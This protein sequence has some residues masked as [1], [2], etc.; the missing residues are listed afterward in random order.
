MIWTVFLIIFVINKQINL[1]K[2]SLYVNKNLL[3]ANSIINQLLTKLVMSVILCVLGICCILLYIFSYEIVSFLKYA[4]LFFLSAGVITTIWETD[5]LFYAGT[6]AA[7]IWTKSGDVF[8]IMFIVCVYSILLEQTKIKYVDIYKTL[9]FIIG[10]I[11]SIS[12]VMVKPL[13]AL[14]V[15]KTFFFIILILT[16]YICISILRYRDKPSQWLIIPFSLFS[17][18]V[19]Y[20]ISWY[21]LDV[22]SSVHKF[23]TKSFLLL[24]CIYVTLQ[25]FCFFQNYRLGLLFG[26]VSNRR[27]Q[28]LTRH[29]TEITELIIKY[30]Y[31]PINK[32]DYLNNMIMNKSIGSLNS[33][34]EDIL[35]DL[36]H[37]VYNLKNHINDISSYRMLTGNQIKPERVKISMKTILE[38]A[39]SE[40]ANE[41]N[42]L[43]NNI[44]IEID[45]NIYIIGDPYL[46]MQANETLLF[47][48]NDF[49]AGNTIDI[50]SRHNNDFIYVRMR[51]NTDTNKI[52]LI[53]K[54]KR[55]INKKKYIDY[56]SHEEDLPLV[57][58]KNIL[59]MH[60]SSTS[61]RIN[62]RKVLEIEYTLPVWV[63]NSTEVTSTNNPYEP[64]SEISD[65]TKIV[66]VSTMPEQI[67]LIKSYLK[68]EPYKLKV[69]STGMDALS[70][71]DKNTNISLVIIGSTFLNMTGYELSEYIR[72]NYSLG[73]LPIILIKKSSVQ[74][75]NENILDN[76]NDVLVTPFSQKEFIQ[77]IYSLIMLKKSVESALKSRLDFLQSQMNP[78]F[79]FNTMSTIM[80][81][82]LEQPMKAYNL[83]SNFSDYL[84]GS[85]FA[86]EL[87]TY[88]PIYREIDLIISYLEIEKARFGEAIQYHINKDC[89]DECLILP[90][91]IEPIV[92]NSIKHSINK[93]KIL[94]I[95]VDVRA[96]G[97][98]VEIQV[99]DDGIGMS[100]ERIDEVMNGQN[101]NSIGLSNLRKRLLIYYNQELH[102]ESSVNIGTTVA[103]KIPIQYDL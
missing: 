100:P 83:L 58:A 50:S 57:I 26:R 25:F 81:L 59:H 18:F 11:L 35:R 74:I 72:K 79:I 68:Y 19:L 30:C 4:R 24:F 70:Y 5:T 8:L 71:I 91:L 54:F 63:D 22:F 40:I 73:Q 64:P 99:K 94:N 9:L 33:K 20:L 39:I 6:K 75:Q 23:Y 14:E 80:Q 47:T 93:H 21:K 36:N 95:S 1:F 89:P 61:M 62:S 3:A 78:H 77:K 76:V 7:K 52:R 41:S 32:I 38:S 51:I 69:F 97:D 16:L 49:N 2:Y 65:K 27:I 96:K 86:G 55:V 98:Y 88:I 10:I 82:C 42:N 43:S 103:F 53:N 87:Y 37:E 29:K 90:L 44:N 85:L 56:I 67:E 45:E 92:E 102:I 17:L 28:D 48:L 46:L 60:Q 101:T 66:L 34:Q 31:T 84:R 13:V 15:L 12:V